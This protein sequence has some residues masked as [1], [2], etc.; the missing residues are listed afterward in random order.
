M[1]TAQAKVHRVQAQSQTRTPSAFWRA[2][3]FTNSQISGAPALLRPDPAINFNWGNGSPAVGVIN[4]DGFA[5]RWTR[6]LDLTPGRYEFTVAADNSVRLWVNN[7]PVIDQWAAAP[8]Q[9]LTAAVDVNEGA[10]VRLEY[11]NRT[12]PA[13]VRLTWAQIDAAP[14]AVTEIAASNTASNTGG[15]ATGIVSGAGILNVRSGPGATFNQLT[16]VADGQVISLAGRDVTNS[17]LQVQ[18]A[19][20]QV[21]WV[22]SIYVTPNLAVTSLPVVDATAI[23]PA[24]VTTTP[25]TAPASGGAATATVAADGVLNV[26][27]GPD[28]AFSVVTT[29]DD[30]A[31]ATLEGRTA[32]ATWLQVRLADGSLGWVSSQFVNANLPVLNLPVLQ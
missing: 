19:G 16:T 8:T 5:V 12:G 27:F 9:A 13:Q 28:T 1:L 22:S 4:A 21:G 11:L 24:A 3:Y 6:L 32:D 14:V 31:S 30:G 29:L 2:E 25:A 18:L 26:R 10:L 20:D 23:V 15:A 17:W 7:Q